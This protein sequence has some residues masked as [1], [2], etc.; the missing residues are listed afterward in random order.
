MPLTLDTTRRT[1]L[2]AAA[3]ASALLLAEKTSARSWAG[4]WAVPSGF[5]A[6]LA[7]LKDAACVPGLSAVL[8]RRGKVAWTHATGVTKAGTSQMVDQDTLFEAA[9]ISKAVFA[10]IAL[11]LA[12]QGV[13]DLDKPLAGYL[14][15]AY[16]PDDPA[17]TVIT[18]RQPWPFATR[19]PTWPPAM[20]VSSV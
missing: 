3:G 19:P 4:G 8:L 15:P 13:L 6:D 14:R 9:S 12:D 2:G 20:W 1:F 10:Y 16:L 7:L 17:Y 11:Q 5:E 18:S